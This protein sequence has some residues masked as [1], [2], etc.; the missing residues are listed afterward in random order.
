MIDINNIQTY[1]IKYAGSKL[2]LLPYIYEITKDLDITN[3]LDG[4]AGTTRVSQL[5][6]QMGYNVTCVDKSEWSKVFGNC[7]LLT[8]KPYSYYQT[9]IDELN[10][11]TPIS[12]WFTQTYSLEESE[13][14]KAPFQYKNLMKLDAIREYIENHNYEEEDKDVLLTSLILGLDK[15]DN[16]I[17]HFTSYLSKWSARSYND[18]VLEVPKYNIYKKQHQVIQN[19]IFNVVNNQSYDLVYFDPPYGSNNEK[20]PSSRVRYNGYYH[21]WKSVILYDKAPVF[22]KAHRREDSRDLVNPSIFEDYH[23]DA[24]GHFLAIKAIEQL[25]D[26]TNSKYILFSYSNGGRATKEQLNY[27]FTK[28]CELINILEIKYKSNVMTSMKWTNEWNK[29]DTDTIEY[30]FLLRKKELLI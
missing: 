6:A 28:R 10:N 22:G 13:L 21:F 9:I 18:L 5:F 24:K 25:L 12:G 3:V 2:K 14:N 17:G 11:L 29:E 26:Q 15:I 8:T 20:M 27:I 23:Q 19:D 1:G 30:L 16:T 7:F 4:F